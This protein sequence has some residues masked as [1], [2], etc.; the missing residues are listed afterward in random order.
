MKSC[1]KRKYTSRPSFSDIVSRLSSNLEYTYN[2]LDLTGLRNRPST[3]KV[4]AICSVDGPKPSNDIS[5]FA[6]LTLHSPCAA[7]NDYYLASI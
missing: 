1:W 2:Y 7:A 3:V 6:S 4:N 5:R